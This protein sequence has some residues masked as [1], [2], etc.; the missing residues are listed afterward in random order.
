[1]RHIQ[2]KILIAAEFNVTANISLG[3]YLVGANS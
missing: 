2:E 1:M 3:A